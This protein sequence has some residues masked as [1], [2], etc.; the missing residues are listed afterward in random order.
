MSCV[1]SSGYSLGC[2]DSAGGV[3]WLAIAAYDTQTTYTTGTC[4]IITGMS[5]TASFYLFEQYV[6]QGMA[7]Q[8]GAYDNITGTNHTV[9]SVMITLE[10]MDA[11]TREQFLALTQAR[12]RVIA[13]TQNGRYFLFG[14]VNGGRASAGTSGPGQNLGDLAGF[15]LTFEFK[16]PEPA[17]EIEEALVN[18]LIVPNP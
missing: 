2:R 3:E 7:S 4:S 1:I 10:K 17:D 5:P 12:V 13:K 18:T 11:C 16:E 14:K 6:E 9:Q 15:Q 8:E